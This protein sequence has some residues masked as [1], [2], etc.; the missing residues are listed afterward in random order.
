M[1]IGFST[2]ACPSWDL[3]TVV[4]K[5]AEF[6]FDG[7]EVRALKGELHLPLAP[8]LAGDTGRVRR[9]LAEHGV[10]LVC[11]GSSIT[12]DSRKRGD[13]A[14]QK[15]ALSDYVEL[16]ARVGSP[17]VRIF[18]GEIQRW[19]HRRAALARIA[20]VL[21]SITPILSRHN[22][23][24]LVE[25][26]GDFRDSEALWYLVD[27][28]GHPLVRVCW[29][30]C[31]ARLVRERPT[32]SLPRLGHKIGLVHLTDATFDDGGVLQEFRPLGE[33]DVEI[34][35]Q[36]ELLKGL[37][38][39]RYVVMEWPRLWMPSLAAA[40]EVLPGAASYL[41]ERIDEKQAVLS[42]YKGDKNAPRFVALGGGVAAPA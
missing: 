31:N 1:K 29:N 17:H 4:Q 34:A 38:F 23:T 41:R 26:G 11:L 33:G 28:V 13:V 27:A 19:D 12:L 22:V 14:R 36:I 42:A 30:Q 15:A 24:L 3:Q 16:A 18:A 21:Q 25:N 5:A 6:G 35:R 40:D 37:A 2:I 39:D 7:V 8:D 32:N 9:L 20:Q 10:E